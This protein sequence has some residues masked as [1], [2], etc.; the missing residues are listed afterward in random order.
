MSA[1]ESR[2]SYDDAEYIRIKREPLH[3]WLARLLWLI[4][5]VLLL[6][7]ALQSHHEREPQAAITA[8][9]LCLVLL[10]AGIIVE[11]VRHVEARPE[12]HLLRNIPH[13]ND[14]DDD[15]LPPE[16]PTRRRTHTA[17]LTHE[18]DANDE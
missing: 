5:L 17:V 6:E 3:V 4:C 11:V 12:A 10:V 15:V 13:V 9:A 8:G 7:Y 16:T 18:K 14:T 1:P 2:N